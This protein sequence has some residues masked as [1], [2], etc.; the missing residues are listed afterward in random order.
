M[1]TVQ[2]VQTH[3]FQRPI[4]LSVQ[5][6]RILMSYKIQFVS[7]QSFQIAKRL[8]RMIMR[9]VQNVQKVIG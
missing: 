9:N 6:V 3:R 7:K 5:L 1:I 8:T 2:N 4:Q